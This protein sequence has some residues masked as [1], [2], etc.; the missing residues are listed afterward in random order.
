MYIIGGVKEKKNSK[1]EDNYN[2]DDNPSES[3]VSPIVS[4]VVSNNSTNMIGGQPVA[5]NVELNGG[6]NLQQGSAVISQTP[7]E[8]PVDPVTNFSQPTIVNPV[9]QPVTPSVNADTVTPSPTEPPIVVQPSVE[10]AIVNPVI[11]PVTPSVNINTNAAVPTEQPAIVQ[12]SVEPTIVNP[13]I[14]PVTPSVNTDTNATVPAEQPIEV[15][16]PENIE[17]I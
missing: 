2:V 5:N 7:I 3:V 17:E 4:P 16:T 9:I 12:P 11:Q 10:P 15:K 14:Q 6:N 8:A 1:K 13:V